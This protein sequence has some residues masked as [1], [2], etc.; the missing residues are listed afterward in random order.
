MREIAPAVVRWCTA[1]QC[2]LLRKFFCTLRPTVDGR[3][4]TFETKRERIDSRRSQYDPFWSLT[5]L[6][7]SPSTNEP[8]RHRVESTPLI[9]RIEKDS[10]RDH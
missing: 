2:P 6:E 1:I 5:M 10:L 3:S 7:N 4:T 8:N 9:W